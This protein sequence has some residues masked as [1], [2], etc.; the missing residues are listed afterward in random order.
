M[1][2][3]SIIEEIKLLFTKKEYEAALK[4]ANAKTNT[5]ERPAGLSN[6][7]GLCKILKINRD[8]KD[9]LSSML[10]FEDAYLKEKKTIHGLDSLCNM[11][12]ISTANVNLIKE[13]SKNI[14]KAQTYYREAIKNFNNNEKLLV[15]GIELYKYFVDVPKIKK[16]MEE[17]IHINPKNK[18]II[19][20]YSFINNYT[21]NWRQENFYEYSKKLEK[22][23]VLN[24]AKHLSE[25]NFKKNDKI[26]IGLVSRDFSRYHSV[27]F[28]VK[29]LLKYLDRSKFETYIFSFSEQFDESSQEIKDSS[30]K[31]SNISNLNNQEVIEQIQKER[32][33]ILIDIGGLTSSKRI[34]IFKSRVSPL[35]ITWLAYCNTIGFK[36]IDYLI[37]DDHLIKDE[38]RF[39]SEKIIKL[40]N[41]WNA[42]SGFDFIREFSETPA[43]K[44]NYI[45]YGSF[46]NFLKISDETAY[47]WSEILK[48]TQNAKL[49]LKSSNNC[50]PKRIIEIFKKNKVYD[51]IEFYNRTDYPSLKEHLNLYKKID[52]ALDT[53]PYN[54]VTTSFE[55]LWCGIPVLTVLGYNFN[56]RCGSSILKNANLD[57]LILKNSEEYIEKALELSN[58][59]NEL[60]ILRKDI[61]DRILNT[62]LFDSKKFASNFSRSLLEVYKR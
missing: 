30:E 54:G 7:L 51:L 19:A 24:N 32:I 53:F 41:I 4:V 44:N 46:N 40:N 50:F 60:S 13:L 14:L 61:F 6:L 28:F 16:N 52:I 57:Q 55:A 12:S 17:I 3:R 59:I 31:W 49:I 26:R 34:E 15:N 42:H 1:I 21:S 58:N 2:S 39:Y 27:T 11:I 25:I 37:A 18:S 10:D 23:F 33:E 43:K 22:H 62:P 8:K 20:R 35:Q 29:K 5:T 38:E 47:A 45:T 9:I 48:K 56:S 36:N